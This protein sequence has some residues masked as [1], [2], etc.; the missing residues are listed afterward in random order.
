MF[1][2]RSILDN[3]YHKSA[4]DAVFFHIHDLLHEDTVNSPNF[5][6]TKFYNALFLNPS[7]NLNTGHT[8]ILSEGNKANGDDDDDLNDDDDA[9]QSEPGSLH[10]IPKRK[11]MVLLNNNIS[12]AIQNF[13]DDGIYMFEE[14]SP[15][16][17][18]W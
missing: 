16:T 15:T 2:Y 9:M 12:K 18:H 13:H 11:T 14:P 6:P 10:S 8:F 3:L 5:D 1:S 4:T 7:S 17:L